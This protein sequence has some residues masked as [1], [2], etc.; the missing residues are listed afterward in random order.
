MDV[1][2]IALTGEDF[3][4]PFAVKEEGSGEDAE[5]FDDLGDVVVVFAVLGAGLWVEEVVTCDQFEDLEIRESARHA[6]QL[7]LD[8]IRHTIAA[9]LQTSVL[10]PHLA[11]RITSGDRYCRVW[12]SFVK[13]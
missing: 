4:G 13:W 5:K 3:L 9:I 10:A 1:A 8:Q 7:A 12:M 6:S 2:E 11:P